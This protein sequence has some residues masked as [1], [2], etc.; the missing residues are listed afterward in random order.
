MQRIV[1]PNFAA[2]WEEIGE[3]NQ[4]EGTY[5]LS[6]MK[7]IQGNHDDKP[8]PPPKHLQLY[9]V[10]NNVRKG[11]L[12]YLMSTFSSLNSLSFFVSQML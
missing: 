9:Y 6:S 12:A 7:D 2:S 11:M 5:A 10:Y 4:T 8:H 3:E 1:K